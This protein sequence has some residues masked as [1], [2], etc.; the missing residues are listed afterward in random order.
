MPVSS[1]IVGP[2]VVGVSDGRLHPDLASGRPGREGV[3]VF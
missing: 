3:S 1:R 2:V